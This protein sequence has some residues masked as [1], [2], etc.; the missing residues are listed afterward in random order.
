MV[1][2]RLKVA[3]ARRSRSASPRREAA[4]LDGDAH[5]LLLE[6]GNAKRL[7]EDRF[8]FRLRVFRLFLSLAAAQ[9]G[10]DHVALDR[11]G[12]DDRHLDDEVVEFARL[13][14]RQHA[15]LGAALDLEDAERVGAADHVVD[16]ASSFGI[17][18]S[19]SLCGQSCR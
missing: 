7:L 8:Q 1:P 16:L 12:P 13:Q 2:L 14:P 6:Q 17:V 9:I 15:H 3:M 5:R 19:S 10:M 18:A 4:G 11:P